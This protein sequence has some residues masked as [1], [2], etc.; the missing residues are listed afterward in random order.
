[1]WTAILEASI[2]VFQPKMQEIVTIE[3]GLH[4]LVQGT[5]NHCPNRLTGLI[6]Q[7]EKLGWTV[8]L[9]ATE[10]MEMVKVN[11]CDQ[12]I[13]H[14]N[15]YLKRADLNTDGELDPI[16]EEAVAQFL[17]KTKEM[18]LWEKYTDL[19]NY[20]WNIIFEKNV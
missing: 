2:L 5:V 3:H 6:T 15:D 13:Y 17:E 1:M 10:C 11:I 7:L 19:N 8:Q 20:E 16:V 4:T 9:K 12:T 18:E 14:S